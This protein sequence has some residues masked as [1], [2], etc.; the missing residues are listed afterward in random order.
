MGRMDLRK[1]HDPTICCVQETHVRFKD[2]KRMKTKEK[3]HE[4]RNWKK[5]EVDILVSDK[6]D[7]KIKLVTI[8]TEGHMIK[9]NLPRRFSSNYKWNITLKNSELLVVCLKLIKYINYTII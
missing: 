2:M 5:N 6:I 4:N 9:I 3:V 1:E 8:D 7:V